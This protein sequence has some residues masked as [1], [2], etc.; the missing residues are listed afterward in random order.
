MSQASYIFDA[1]STNFDELV[2][3]NSHKGPVLVN[4]WSPKAGPCFKLWPLL[5]KLAAEYSGRFLLVNINTEKQHLFAR[6]NGINSLPTVKLYRSGK[7]V[8]QVHGAE[9]ESTYRAL[10][11]RHIIR[12][13]DAAVSAALKVYQAGDSGKSFRMLADIAIEDLE[14]LR[15]PLTLAR[16]LFKEARYA[17][18]IALL[19]S[20]PEGFSQEQEVISLY[21]HAE[22]FVAAENAPLREGLEKKI[23]RDPEDLEA[24]YQLAAVN[25]LEDNYEGALQQLLEIMQRD[26][27]FMDAVGRRGTTAIFSILGS[28]HPLVREYRN[29]LLNIL[30]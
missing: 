19:T 5:E 1:D 30:H 9:S 23:S 25:L 27:E 4:Y 21:T 8:E 14:N 13:S 6:D 29:H 28:T 2:V 18:V 7:V 12:P 16:L 3:A 17:D 10:I 24:R 15:V 20:L 26:P 11:D 22:F